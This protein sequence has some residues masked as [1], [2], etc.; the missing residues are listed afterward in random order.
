[1][2]CFEQRLMLIEIIIYRVNVV[3]YFLT[4]VHP[5]LET[6]GKNVWRLNIFGKLTDKLSFYETAPFNI[7]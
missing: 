2:N 1:M 5:S 7:N 3:D 4:N 6:K